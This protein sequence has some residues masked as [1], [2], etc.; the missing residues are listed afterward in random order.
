MSLKFKVL[1]PKVV[2]VQIQT[3]D[4]RLKTF[5][6]LQYGEHSFQGYGNANY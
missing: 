4:F 5:D 3:Q 2:N 1:S 6:L